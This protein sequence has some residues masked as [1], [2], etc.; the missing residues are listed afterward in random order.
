MRDL[1]RLLSD[2]HDLA[3]IGQVEPSVDGNIA[4]LEGD[5]VR[6]RRNV[7]VLESVQSD[8][9]LRQDIRMIF[10]ASHVADFDELRFLA[11]LDRSHRIV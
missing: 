8:R 9:P 5:I 11:R 2:A 7:I 6:V 3:G 1:D 10:A 4:N